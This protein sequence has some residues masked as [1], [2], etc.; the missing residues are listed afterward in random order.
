MPL[1]V[2]AEALAATIDGATTGRAVIC[3]GHRR[4]FCCLCVVR[5]RASK[6][7]IHRAHKIGFVLRSFDDK[8]DK[9]LFHQRAQIDAN[10]SILHTSRGVSMGPLREVKIDPQSSARG[11]AGL[12]LT[13][14]VK[15]VSE[16]R[17]VC[18]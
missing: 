12:V 4:C 10:G 5:A 7:R 9:K 8:V 3:E 6:K 13:L 16:A 18:N 2:A 15:C 17:E 14:D 1:A 11:D